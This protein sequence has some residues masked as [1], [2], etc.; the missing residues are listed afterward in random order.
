MRRTRR[1]SGTRASR[2]VWLIMRKILFFEATLLHWR[3]IHNK[4]EYSEDSLSGLPEKRLGSRVSRFQV[5]AF[6]GRSTTE[7]VGKKI[8]TCTPER[9]GTRLARCLR[10]V[11][12]PRS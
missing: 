2:P 5:P 11:R 6:H 3:T 7:S 12:S 10:I 8:P 1:H 9:I 4:V